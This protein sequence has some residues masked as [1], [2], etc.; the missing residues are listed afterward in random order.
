MRRGGCQECR[1]VPGVVVGGDR[2]TSGAEG[3]DSYG[4]ELG[5]SEGTAK[6]VGKVGH[7]GDSV[8][9]YSSMQIEIERRAW[10]KYEKL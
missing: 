4:K 5:G 3:R 6:I 9:C 2:E 1:S 10:S 8:H 7:E